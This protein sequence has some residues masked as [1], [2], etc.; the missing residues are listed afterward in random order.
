MSKYDAVVIGAGHNGLICASYLAQSRMKVL[1]LEAKDEVGGAA[2]TCELWP[3]IK[4]S[5]FSYMVSLLQSK[6]INDLDLRRHGYRLLP[7]DSLFTPFENG[8]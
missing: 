3:G 5:R 1:V 7:N 4:V 8:S 2:R 6:I